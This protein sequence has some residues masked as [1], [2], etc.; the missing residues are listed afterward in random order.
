MRRKSNSALSSHELTLSAQA[1]MA[2]RHFLTQPMEKESV[3]VIGGHA[4]TDCGCRRPTRQGTA[5]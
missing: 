1:H 3:A 4:G 5:P 2:D